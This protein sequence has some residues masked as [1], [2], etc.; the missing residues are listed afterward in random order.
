M[1]T[2]NTLREKKLFNLIAIGDEAAFEEL[3]NLYVPQL[4]QVIY[5][6]V[7][8]DTAVQDIAQEVFLN[9][10]L[11]RDR[12]PAVEVPQLWIFRIAYNH[13]FRYLRRHKLPHVVDWNLD[14]ADLIST[15]TED[16]VNG[17]EVNRLIREA[18]SQL[19]EQG[20]KIF[21]MNRLSGMKPADIAGELQIS[22]QGVR[23]SLTRSAKSVRDYLSEH[24]IKIP[25]I[26]L[27]FFK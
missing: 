19:P 15:E 24:G 5:P 6:I 11:G 10:W 9:L 25:L 13:S 2:T 21:E 26:L 8:S 20:R 17:A 22:I 14:D 16:A 27:L 12:L 23:N 3:F 18:I 4:Q 1:S 7:R